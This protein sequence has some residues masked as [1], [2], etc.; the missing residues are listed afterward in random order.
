MSSNEGRDKISEYRQNETEEQKQERINKQIETQLE[1]YDVEWYPM[2][3]EC[4]IRTKQTKLERYDNENY[5]NPEKGKQ[6]CLERYGVEYYSQYTYK[7]NKSMYQWHDY[8]LP[9]GKWIKLQGYEH[10]GLE[11][12]LNYYTEEEI[13]YENKDMPEIWYRW[14]D[15][16]WHRYFP[17][18]YAPKD[19]LVIE[20]KSDYTYKVDLEKNLLKEEATKCLGYNF[21]FYVF[22]E[23][24]ER[25]NGINI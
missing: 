6:T 19:N 9:S 25:I 8:Q 21:E 5:N 15:N 16:S 24:K 20:V 13:L 7:N 10:I 11:I 3:D 1:R 23:K 4:K 14:N 17:D 18:F 12:L 22:N 2:T